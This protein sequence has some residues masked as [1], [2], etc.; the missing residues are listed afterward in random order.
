MRSF[1]LTPTSLVKSQGWRAVNEQIESSDLLHRQRYWGDSVF[2]F[3]STFTLTMSAF[4]L[5]CKLSFALEFLPHEYK[6]SVPKLISPMALQQF[7]LMLWLQMVLPHYFLGH[8][9]PLLEMTYNCFTV[10]S[11]SM[12]FSETT[13]YI[14]AH[15]TYTP[16]VHPC[17][18]FA[19]LSAIQTNYWKSGDLLTTH[20][21]VWCLSWKTVQQCMQTVTVQIQSYTLTNLQVTVFVCFGFFLNQTLF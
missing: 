2:C 7:S 9:L 16:A 17:G 4:S 15:P 21:T 13:Q 1:K 19:T 8:I 12:F 10:L 11:H 6:N 14:L 20:S 18:G 3:W 5:Q